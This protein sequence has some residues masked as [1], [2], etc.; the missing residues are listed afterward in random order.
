MSGASR[1][2]HLLGLPD[3]PDLRHALVRDRIRTLCREAEQARLAGRLRS[4]RRAR[5]RGG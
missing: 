5:R 4:A 2:P 3:L 1:S